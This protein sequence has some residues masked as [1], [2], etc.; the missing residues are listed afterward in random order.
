MLFLC[1]FFYISPGNS[2]FGTLYALARLYLRTR[3]QEAVALYLAKQG[4]AYLTQRG[5]DGSLP[6]AL[7]WGLGREAL[8]RKLWPH[9]DRF[10]EAPPAKDRA[11]GQ[12]Q[13]CL[14]ALFDQF[15][16]CNESSLSRKELDLKDY[17]EGIHFSEARK[18]LV[19]A[20]LPMK[21]G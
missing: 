7:A 17:K 9:A 3:P 4:S 12:E 14:K 8:L 13:R 1:L 10:Q 15:P 11:A 20:C 6:E 18:L 21:D 16:L 19:T 5:P 2:Y